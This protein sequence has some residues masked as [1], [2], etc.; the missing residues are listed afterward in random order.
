MYVP[1]CINL[2]EQMK[3]KIFEKRVICP[4]VWCGGCFD[5]AGGCVLNQCPCCSW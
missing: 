5:V 1:Q 3:G 2:F 4:P